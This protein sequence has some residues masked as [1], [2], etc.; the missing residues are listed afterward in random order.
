MTLIR[1]HE[2]AYPDGLTLRPDNGR[3]VG[4][5][6]GAPR[7][8]LIACM[9]KS[10]STFLTDVI[11]QLPGFRRATLV[12]AHGR[13]EHELDEFC[14]QQ[15][16]RFD[17]V[18]QSHV[19]YSSWTGEMCRDYSL[20]PV[21]LVR[22]LLDVIVSLRDHVRRES[23]VNPWFFAEA[24]HAALDDARLEQMIAQL[25]LPWYVNFYMGWRRAPDSLMVNY[26][27][28]THAPAETVR[29]ILAFAGASASVASIE[30]AVARVHDHNGS[31]LNVGAS[32]RGSSLRPET[33]RTA[34]EL[35]DFYPEAAG[36]PY[37]QAVKAQGLAALRG[38][39]APV[40]RLAAPSMAK[41]RFPSVR[42][43]WRKIAPRVLM[44]GLLPLSAVSLALLYW[45]WP[46]DL[47]P[48][49]RLYGYLDDVA[50]L[51][52][53]GVTAGRLTKYRP[54]SPR[55]RREASLWRT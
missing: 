37:V 18:A 28:L 41:G 32:G 55:L 14:L 35:I 48:D 42:R 43:W 45:L 23:A 3:A 17:F 27:D 50:V 11:A 21:V 19:R 12:P 44:R 51:L 2:R 29:A 8:I 16:D 5:G 54:R 25:A 47:L 39:P 6:F 26:E 20:A 10:G 38:G 49:S 40:V 7:H 9:P 24:R 34:L 15:F 30:A 46:A 1:R 36:D 22:G 13:R 31:R 52:V 4:L 53:C 33:I